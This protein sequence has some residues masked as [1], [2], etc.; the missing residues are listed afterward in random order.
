MRKSGGREESGDRRACSPGA[1][2]G[3]RAWLCVF[4]RRTA[5]PCSAP[6][7]P[8]LIRKRRFFKK[9]STIYP[10]KRSSL[11]NFLEVTGCGYWGSI[12]RR[13]S[14]ASGFSYRT[15]DSV[16]G[17]TF[18]CLLE[19]TCHHRR[20]SEARCRVA[21]GADRMQATKSFLLK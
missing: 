18:C 3:V 1:E 12:R 8:D 6:L 7:L 17:V 4:A 19:R 5:G 20:M 13:I 9:R 15:K 14:S 16:F 10:K 2:R 11:W 21:L